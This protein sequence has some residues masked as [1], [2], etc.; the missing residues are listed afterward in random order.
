M[1]SRWKVLFVVVG[2]SVVFLGVTTSAKLWSNSPHETST[3][4]QTDNENTPKRTLTLL[5]IQ[6][7]QNGFMPREVN[8]PAGNFEFLMINASGE[9]DVSINL[10]REQGERLESLT[11][12]R[13]R[14]LRKQVQLAAGNYLLTVP[15][16]PDWVCRLT[17]T[18]PN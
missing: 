7:R 17:I 18:N 6:L 3:Q 9:H 13:G 5:P 15:D 14:N 1:S 16:H 4:P 12:Q 11:P 8:E 2:L 10:E